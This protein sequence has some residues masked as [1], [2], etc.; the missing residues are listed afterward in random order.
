MQIDRSIIFRI[1]NIIVGCFMI[2][3][4]VV[5]ILTGGKGEEQKTGITYT[6]LCFSSRLPSIHTRDL[7]YLVWHHGFPV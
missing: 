2:I 5:T 6:L 4:G 7:L 1:V 3:G